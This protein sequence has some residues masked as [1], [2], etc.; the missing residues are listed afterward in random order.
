MGIRGKLLLLAVGN[1]DRI[2]SEMAEQTKRRM[3]MNRSWANFSD[4]EKANQRYDLVPLGIRREANSGGKA[5]AEINESI[6]PKISEP[7]A[8]SPS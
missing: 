1:V 6:L 2:K 3:N 8:K 7:F 4:W 5:V